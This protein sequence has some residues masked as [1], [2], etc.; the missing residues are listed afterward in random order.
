MV[1]NHT[2]V[3][4]YIGNANMYDVRFRQE[5][6]MVHGDKLDFLSVSALASS[7]SCPPRN[8]NGNSRDNGHRSFCI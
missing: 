3:I 2:Y 8:I 5:I 7:S 4:T 6:A 1:L